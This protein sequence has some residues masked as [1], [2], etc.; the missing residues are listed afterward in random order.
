MWGCLGRRKSPFERAGWELGA[1][2]RVPLKVE[3]E[4]DADC[5]GHYLI[6]YRKWEISSRLMV[7]GLPMAGLTGC[8][9]RGWAG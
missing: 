2:T 6:I 4:G 1:V 9:M 5:I 7:L 8:K 3:G